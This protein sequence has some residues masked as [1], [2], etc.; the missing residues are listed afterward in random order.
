MTTGKELWARNIS[1]GR[2]V[3]VD[4]QS[5][6]YND[7]VYVSTVPGTSA[8]DF[9]T[10]GSVG[11]IYALD[12]ET[13]RE[14]WSFSTVDTPDIWGNREVNSGGGSWYTP[15]IDLLTG[16]IFWGVGNPAPWP[17]TSK[18]PNGS[19]RPGP[20]LYTDSCLLWIA[21]M[22]VLSGTAR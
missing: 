20:N 1:T 12:Q 21:V 13:G 22:A 17:G 11:V 2:T 16:T 7:M 19:S 3:G 9:Y 5:A 10:G 6:V 8:D 18:Y 14:R 4:I 15:S